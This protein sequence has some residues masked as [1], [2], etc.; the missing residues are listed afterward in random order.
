MSA[1]LL[2]GAAT[3]IAPTFDHHLA[4]YGPLESHDDMIGT[5]ERA[6]L[7]GRGGGA[8]PTAAKL[9]AVA[10]AGGRPVVV[11]NAVEGEPASGKDH[12]LLHVAPHLVLDGAVLACRAVGAREAVVAIADRTGRERASV[13][14]AIAQRGRRDGRVRLRTAAVPNRFVTGEETALVRALAGRDAKP[15]LKPPYPFERGLG[16]AP[17]LVS[18][19]ETLAHVAL[20][21]RFGAE[22]FR[23]AGAPDSPGTALI[24]LG[25]AVAQPGVHEIELGTPLDEALEQAGGATGPAQAILVGG[26][27]GRWVTPAEAPT[28]RLTPDVLGA[29][30]IIVLPADVCAVAE[31][32]R[33]LA[34]L[35]DE[36]AGQCGPCV[37][38]LRAIAETVSAPGKSNRRPRLE[39][40]ATL[41]AGR[42][43]CRHPDGAAGFLR[44]A[45]D[46][47]ADEFAQHAK[48]GRCSRRHVR[49][50][51]LPTRP[52]R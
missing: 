37:H 26:Y 11:A 24:T 50:L 21:A 29:G 52:S 8:F 31:C 41:V 1:R 34:Y 27:F 28:L 33:T 51:P 46:V 6:G 49:V 3:R 48:R 47:F 35:A 12:A 4:L 14:N 42:G 23:G 19:A 20:I 38:G 2:A 36:S 44:S 22:W 43:A 15:S 39:Q 25:G 16:G 13:E 30:A 17:T 32:A 40:L 9:R 45:L 7:R 18:N 10:T 5:V